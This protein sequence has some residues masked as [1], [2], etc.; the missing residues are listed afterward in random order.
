MPRL[1]GDCHTNNATPRLKKN[2]SVEM[3]APIDRGLSQLQLESVRPQSSHLVEMNAPIDRGLTFTQ[4][5][6]LFH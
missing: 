4:Q 5:A 3:N 2:K 1:I 6:H